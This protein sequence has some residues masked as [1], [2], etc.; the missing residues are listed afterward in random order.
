MEPALPTGFGERDFFFESWVLVEGV[1]FSVFT[2]T[3]SC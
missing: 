3:S 1:K 2:G